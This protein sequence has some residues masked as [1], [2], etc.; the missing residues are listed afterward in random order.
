MIE[1]VQVYRSIGYRVPSLL[2]KHTAPHYYEIAATGGL[3]IYKIDK[4]RCLP[5]TLNPQMRTMMKWPTLIRRS[6]FYEDDDGPALE[7]DEAAF[8]NDPR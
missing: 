3:E 5:F 4:P 6:L 2:S 8:G 7:G 1:M